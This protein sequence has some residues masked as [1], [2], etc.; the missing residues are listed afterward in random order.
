M[1]TSFHSEFLKWL[2]RSQMLTEWLFQIYLFDC[3]PG[4]MCYINPQSPYD[5]EH[6]NELKSAAC[7]GI[8]GFM[9]CICRY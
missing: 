7:E 8:F 5:A 4:Q 9:K 2:S 6:I 1:S 3:M